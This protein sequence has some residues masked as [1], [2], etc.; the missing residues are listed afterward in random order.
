[1]PAYSTIS[2]ALGNLSTYEG[3]LIR[4]HASNPDTSG[5]SQVDNVQ[6]FL[7]QRDPHIGRENK[8]NISIAGIYIELDG[9]GVDP[10]AFDPEDKRRHLALNLRTQFDMEKLRKLLDYKHIQR[11]GQMHWVAALINHVP[12]LAPMKRQVS[13]QF[14]TTCARLRIPLHAT[15]VHPMASSG[16]SE[17]V[18][19]EL[20]DGMLDFSAQM[21]NQPN[22]YVRKL[23]LVGG[24]ELMYEKLLQLKVYMQFHSDA[25]KRFELLEPTLAGWHTEWT[26]LSRIY[27]AHWDSIASQ[28]PSSL[29]HSA[30]K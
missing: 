24:N 11:I 14:H 17:T 30:A 29:G 4:E 18:T 25:F 26:D 3:D 1:M 19:T 10:K 9:A 13:H 16:K 8:M 5:C 21:G 23:T 2:R 28:D 27:E 22:D 15:K 12:H 20:K 6:N 7:I